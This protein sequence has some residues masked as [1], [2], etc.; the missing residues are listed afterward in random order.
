MFSHC[1]EKNRD[2]NTVT[3]TWFQLYDL[4]SSELSCLDVSSLK[5]TT[6]KRSVRLQTYT[7]LL[8]LKVK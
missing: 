4:H 1:D 5:D 2:N 3:L 8:L 7:L 6:V